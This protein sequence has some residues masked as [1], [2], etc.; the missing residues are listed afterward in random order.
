MT[1][2]GSGINS[3]VNVANQLRFITLQQNSAKTNGS[4]YLLQTYGTPAQS[5]PQASQGTIQ[6]A[7]N[8][9]TQPGYQPANQVLNTDSF[10]PSNKQDKW[11]TDDG[12][13]SG[14]EKLVNFGKGIVSPVTIM[15]KS[16]KN[17]AIGALG[18]AGSG[19][20]IAA[21]G[22]AIAPV[23]VAAGVVGGGIGLL[24]S[25]Y[26]AINAKTDDEARKA[27]QELG[28]ST[29][30]VAGS[31][32]GSKAALKGAGIDTKGMNFL[33]STIECFKSTPSQVGKSAAAF[34]S[35]EALTNIKNVL[36]IK[37][38]DD[39]KQ[40]IDNTSPV[41]NEKTSSTEGVQ[42]NNPE[43]KPDTDINTPKDT[44]SEGAAV[45]STVETS[46]AEGAGG[47]DRKDIITRKQKNIKKATGTSRTRNRRKNRIKHEVNHKQA[48]QVKK[49][50][51]DI[52]VVLDEL[53]DNS[54]LDI[55]F[56][57]RIEDI[58]RIAANPMEDSNQDITDLISAVR[59][60]ESCK[61]DPSSI[62]TEGKTIEFPFDE[63]ISYIEKLLSKY[64]VEKIAAAPGDSFNRRLMQ[65]FDT[66]ETLNK[67]LVDTIFEI[68]SSGFK[69]ADKQGTNSDWKTKVIR[70]VSPGD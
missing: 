70:Y 28:L 54:D 33:K 32:A 15:F 3:S 23:M 69:K 65:A 27:W 47:A 9:Q 31:I 41:Q 63:A 4:G 50:V 51:K 57:N 36:H 35:G 8:Y 1:N 42:R 55:Q 52:T 46:R 40:N 10:V 49:E 14:K 21:T 62:A 30:T 61:K 24:K 5:T 17:F 12:K 20:L 26:S 45:D 66:K 56:R 25:G 68:V 7:A 60:L 37:K 64:E 38:K 67:N 59:H 11:A 48:Q 16:P 39:I 43:I 34:A 19:L 6:T 18:I 44:I 29:T 58:R 22:G 53:A 13:I 2:S